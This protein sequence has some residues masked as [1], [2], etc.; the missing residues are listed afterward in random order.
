MVSDTAGGYTPDARKASAFVQII[1]RQTIE[2][3][4]AENLTDLLHERGIAGF[5]HTTPWEASITFLRGNSVNS[6]DSEANSQLLFLIDGRRSGVAN[7]NQLGLAN[8]DHIEIIR[9]PEMYKYAASSH[10]GVVNIITKRGGGKPLE[11]KI[12]G[13]Y[14]SWDTYGGQLTLNGRY[15]AFDYYFTYGH[16]DMDADYK[17]GRQTT[18][19]NTSYDGID[20]MSLNLG[21]TFSE[22]HRLGLVGYVY[23]LDNAY[24]P[25][26]YVPGTP[27]A[28]SRGEVDRKTWM[29]HLTYEG[30]DGDRLSWQAS[31]GTSHDEFAMLYYVTP[32]FPYTQST[33][34]FLARG[35]VSYASELFDLDFGLDYTRYA[36]KNGGPDERVGA[37]IYDGFNR[38][39]TSTTTDFGV[40]LIGTLKLLD[41][42]L[43]LTGGLRYDRWDVWDN[44]IGDE[45]FFLYP[46]TEYYH[47]ANGL[48]PTRRTFDGLS[49]SI[50]VSYLPTQWL[51]FRASY[52][53]TF[54]APS[55][56]Q[57]FASNIT[58][59]Y[60]ES[61]DPRLR[62]EKADNWEVG[63]D[64]NTEAVTAS[65]SYFDS[66]VKDNVFPY[67]VMD[68]RPIFTGLSRRMIQNA[69]RRTAGFEFAFSFDVAKLLGHTGYELRPYFGLNYLT[70]HHFR[71]SDDPS[72]YTNR[73]LPMIWVPESSYFYGLR[74]R[75]FAFNLEAAI[76]FYQYGKMRWFNPGAVITPTSYDNYQYGNF[77]LAD[78]Y[79]KQTLLD[80]GDKGHLDFTLNVTNL[81]DEFYT[82]N[83]WQPHQIP[84]MPGRAFY[85]S[86]SYNY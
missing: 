81:F 36:L 6:Q 5:N 1:D 32:F 34:T 44:A 61:G 85:V 83:Q 78:L 12:E 49:P 20:N 55:G 62:P 14:G 86:L 16:S 72:L 4:P 27:R 40:Y 15:D 57:L 28:P 66:R 46:Y 9:G 80:F 43:N 3:S 17:D 56:R 77:T 74:Y 42:N 60:Y 21:Y 19:I 39:P 67:P 45:S 65:F 71:L 58:E 31:V 73:W 26:S 63:F 30:G 84:Y 59:G 10:G 11:A 13:K 64:I 18:V 79:I 33:D 41:N 22:N 35:S 54:R 2:A 53:R 37:T 24:K 82:Y 51:K 52:A 38:H 29:Y 68:P 47:F 75:N 25:L 76:N 50:G 48:R 7:A 8:I 23:N 70:K 69:D